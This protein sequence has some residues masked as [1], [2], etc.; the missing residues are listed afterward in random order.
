MQGGIPSRAT[1]NGQPHKAVVIDDVCWEDGETL[2]NF[3]VEGEVTPVYSFL[4]RNTG[5]AESDDEKI[6]FSS[7]RLPISFCV[8]RIFTGPSSS[9]SSARA[10]KA[11]CP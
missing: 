8:Q 11:G 4:C 6:C 2:T 5:C 3:I 7:L 10:P 9:L 1:H